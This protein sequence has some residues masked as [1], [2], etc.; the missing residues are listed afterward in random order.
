LGADPDPFRSG[1]DFS[2][3]ELTPDELPML[4]AWHD[5]TQ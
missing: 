2:A 3:K 5:P 4:G 1:L